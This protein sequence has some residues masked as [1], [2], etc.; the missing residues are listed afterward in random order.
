MSDSYMERLQRA[1]AQLGQIAKAIEQYRGMPERHGNLAKRVRISYDAGY[2]ETDHE[3]AT[4]VTKPMAEAWLAKIVA[5]AIEKAERHRDERLISAAAEIE[6]IRAIL[7][8]LAASAAIELGVMAR[9][10]RDE[11]GA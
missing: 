5:E 10:L 11:A 9:A 7:P 1:V 3:A 2:F 8:S 4:A 6:A